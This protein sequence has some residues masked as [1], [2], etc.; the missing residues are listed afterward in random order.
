MFTSGT[1][2]APRAAMLSHGN[3]LGQPRP[4]PLGR[5]SSCTADDVVYGV[6]PLFHIFGLNV[7]LGA[8]AAARRH[9]SCSCSA[10]TRPPRSTPIRDRGVTVIPGAPPLWL[11]FATSTTPRPTASPS[12]RL[13]LS[14]AAQ[15][16]PRRRSARCASASACELAEG[17]GLTEASPV[18]TTSAGIGDP[19][20]LGRQGA[21][22]RRGAPRRRRRRRRRSPATPARSGC[23]APTC[24]TATGTT[25]R[26]PPGCSTADG[27]LRTGD[28]AVADDDGY[29]YLVDR[30]KD[31]I[32]VCGFNVY[33]AEVEEVLAEHPAVAEVGVVGV[34]HPHTGEA[35]KAFVVRATPGATRRRGHADRLVPATTSPAT[36]ARR[37]SCS[38]TQLPQN[39]SGKLLRRV[40]RCEP[41]ACSAAG[42]TA[43][44]LATRNP[45]NSTHDPDEQRDGERRGPCRGGRRA[46]RWPRA[47]ACRRRSAR[48]RA[49]SR[50]GDAAARRR[51]QRRRA[52]AQQPPR[53]ST[54]APPMITSAAHAGADRGEDPR[55][56]RR[57]RPCPSGSSSPATGALIGATSI[58]A[59]GEAAAGTSQPPCARSPARWP[60]EQVDRAERQPRHVED[61]ADEVEDPEAGQAPAARP[62]PTT[63]APAP[64]ANMR[65]RRSSTP[66][67]AAR[68]RRSQRSS[69]QQRERRRRPASPRR[70]ARRPSVDERY[71]RP[72]PRIVSERRQTV[73]NTCTSRAA[74]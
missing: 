40:A 55:A 6:L 57:T 21:R 32:I 4:E 25:R 64:S 33:P 52:A 3:L 72:W 58:D 66:A 47:R 35:V 5:R 30:A 50:P 7:V 42:A 27:W 37:R 19:A 39:V 28:I 29:L 44:L 63:A 8:H 14:G 49:T 11:A 24:S 34:P 41:T 46:C 9:A 10:S 60:A 74:L 20:R 18:V 48:C 53:R 71:V 31:L 13:A 73:V 12:V 51:R 26:R 69:V 59:G 36:S 61:G 23:R 16:C 68:R 56:R 15:A 70:R 62:R 65:E 17:Y 2:G 43:R 22:R 54:S 38:S 67:R 45:A 1:A